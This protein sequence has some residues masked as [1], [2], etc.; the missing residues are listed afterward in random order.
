MKEWIHT[1]IRDHICTITIQNP[2]MNIL[3]K[4]VRQAFVPLMEELKQRDD[5]RVIILRGEGERAFCAGADLN[6][7]GELT[8]ETVRLFLQEDC[9]IYDIVN[10]MPQPVIAAIDGYAFGGGFE[11]ALASDFR[12]L[13][14]RA[15][16]CAAGV[17]VGLVVSTTRLVRLLGEAYA[18][19]VILTGRTISAEEAFQRGLANQIVPPDQLMTASEEWAKLIAARAPIAVRKAKQAIQRT[20]DLTWTEG[21][22]MELDAFIECQATRDHHHAIESFF[23]KQ[24]PSFIGK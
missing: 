21:M 16:L 14:D 6:E 20:M 3:T 7:E 13:T 22:A 9:R 10:E 18:K 8:Q 24:Q 15:A 5:V 4:E 2:P 17:K 23:K 12:I 1:V 19:E 11:L